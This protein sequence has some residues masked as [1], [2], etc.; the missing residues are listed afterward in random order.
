MI[1]SNKSMFLLLYQTFSSDGGRYRGVPS[2][3]VRVQ[4]VEVPSWGYN[5]RKGTELDTELIFIDDWGVSSLLQPIINRHFCLLCDFPLSSPSLFSP[6]LFP[7]SLSR[8][9]FHAL[10]LMHSLSS[11]LLALVLSLKLTLCRNPIFLSYLLNYGIIFSRIS[12]ILIFLFLVSCSTPAHLDSPWI[13]FL[14]VGAN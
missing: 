4:Q 12:I 1:D 2:H 11:S 14:S 8:T 9:L 13:D 7:P 3:R 10:S 6:S 5:N